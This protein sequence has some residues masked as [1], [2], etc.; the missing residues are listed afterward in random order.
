MILVQIL[1][2]LEKARGV[3]QWCIP[4]LCAGGRRFDLVSLQKFKK[5][6]GKAV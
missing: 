3:V 1:L 5:G 2:A 4:P 6:R